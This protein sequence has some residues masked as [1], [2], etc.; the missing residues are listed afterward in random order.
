MLLTVPYKIVAKI[1]KYGPCKKE[2]KKND[3]TTRFVEK[4][5]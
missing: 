4:I 1:K 3:K 2:E 5:N